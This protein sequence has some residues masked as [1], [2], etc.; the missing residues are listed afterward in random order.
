MAPAR[1]RASP[2]FR[3]DDVLLPIGRRGADTA[4]VRHLDRCDRAGEACELLQLGLEDRVPDSYG[5]VGARRDD[6]A[7]RATRELRGRNPVLVT[8]HDHQLVAGF[9]MS[10]P[11]RPV[12]ARGHDVLPVGAE[13]DVGERVRVACEDRVQAPVGGPPDAPEPVGASACDEVSVRAERHRDG[14]PALL[15]S[16]YGRDVRSVLTRREPCR[17]HRLSA[18]VCCRARSRP[19]S[20]R[21]AG[22]CDAPGR[23]M[24]RQAERRRPR[25]PRRVRRQARSPPPMRHSLRE[26]R[27]CCRPDGPHA[28]GRH[29]Q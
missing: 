11:C 2:G 14:V 3:P 24:R 10:D 28:P 5:S 1:R 4:A 17:L 19:I 22:M 15:R 29:S 23:S 8:G 25:S 7:S 21:H 27:Q 12:L 26:W 6:R 9:R 20:R 18:L 13:R 16:A